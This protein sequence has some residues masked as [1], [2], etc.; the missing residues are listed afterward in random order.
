MSMI[1]NGKKIMN[2]K[3]R[4]L[5]IVPA[6]MLGIGLATA[7]FA[8]SKSPPVPASTSM[9][10]AGADT[11]GA[12]KSAYTGTATALSDTTITTKVKS[13]FASG[14]GIKS[15]DIHVVTT[16]GVVTLTGQVPSS[17]M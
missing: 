17:H 7:A 15:N 11:V 12:A 3:N 8:Q 9:D 6:M 16:A 2:S 13:A 4:I 1:M 10:Q 5:T 14:K